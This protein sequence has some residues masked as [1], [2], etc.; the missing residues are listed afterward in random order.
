MRSFFVIKYP[1]NSAELVHW[2]SLLDIEVQSFRLSQFMI[3]NNGDF[4]KP[5]YFVSFTTVHATNH[6]RL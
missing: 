4:V 6:Q 1:Q 3:E 5:N 2:I